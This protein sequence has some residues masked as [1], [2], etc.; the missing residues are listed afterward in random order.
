MQLL[1]CFADAPTHLARKRERQTR[2]AQPGHGKNTVFR[3]Q[4][5]VV[6][7]PLQEETEGGAD[8]GPRMRRNSHEVSVRVL[9]ECRE[10]GDACVPTMSSSS[11]DVSYSTCGAAYVAKHD[12]ITSLPLNQLC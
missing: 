6:Q 12:C 2:K 9:L 4:I 1:A 7:G 8:G 3:R 11:D 5:H 10:K